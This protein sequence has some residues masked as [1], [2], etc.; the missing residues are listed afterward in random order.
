MQLAGDAHAGDDGQH[1]Q[2]DDIVEN[3]GT[4]NDPCLGGVQCAEVAEHPGGD[5]D[6]RGDEHGADEDRFH[7]GVAE[8]EHQEAAADERSNDPEHGDDE[9][10]QP[11][12]QQVGQPRLEADEEEE[13]DDTEF[14]DRLERERQ[15]LSC[16]LSV[17]V[18]EV[19]EVGTGDADHPECEGTQE[20]TS[21]DLT[22]DRRLAQPQKEFT[23]Q[24]RGDEDE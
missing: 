22:D 4:Q 23:G 9:R 24:L 10:A 19:D 3:G 7:G 1:E 14:G 11:D 15:P 16:C 2:T 5:P 18:E 20:D 17:V 21:E 6:A 8:G 13:N 12:A